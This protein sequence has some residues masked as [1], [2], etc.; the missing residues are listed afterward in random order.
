[1]L[2]TPIRPYSARD[3]GDM[4][5]YAVCFLAVVIPNSI[6]SL[7]FVALVHDDSAQMWHTG[8]YVHKSWLG[9]VQF[10]N[11]FRED[12]L[13]HLAF[14]VSP[15]LARLFI[16]IVYL[17][18]G[19]LSL[20]HLLTNY[21]Y[22]NKNV[23]LAASTLPFL[24]LG[25]WQIPLG[26]N[27]SYVAGDV[28]FSL[29]ASILICNFVKS[30][31]SLS[32]YVIKLLGFYILL[33]EVQPSSVV[34]APIIVVLAL[35][36]GRAGL[37]KRASIFFISLLS[38]FSIYTQEK[39]ASRMQPVEAEVLFDNLYAFYKG[40]ANVLS[41]GF[42]SMIWTIFFWSLTGLGLSLAFVSLLQRLRTLLFY[43]DRYFSASHI[44][45]V[46]Y[47]ASAVLLVGYVWS[48]IPY[49]LVSKNINPLFS[50][51]YY[52]IWQ[53]FGWA[54]FSVGLYQIVNLSLLPLRGVLH[55]H[56]RG[57][58]KS[59]NQVVFVSVVLL[60]S[61]AKLFH[62]HP[63]VGAKNSFMK[64]LRSTLRTEL[65]AKTYVHDQLLL[66]IKNSK[67]SRIPHYT[68]FVANT[69]Y[70]NYLVKPRRIS[71][72]TFADPAICGTHFRKRKAEVW[73]KYMVDG[74][75]TSKSMVI[76]EYDPI[77]RVLATKEYMIEIESGEVESGRGRFSF[78]ALKEGD[79]FYLDSF[80]GR[81]GLQKYISNNNIP[82]NKIAYGEAAI[83]GKCDG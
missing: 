49:A 24:S 27:I 48:L 79:I 11:A 4:F 35:T 58:S 76:L 63:A 62:Q 9:A 56:F 61:N 60:F 32:S 38:L 68:N 30:R 3:G 33:V 47:S 51:R 26:I 65:P 77:E 31:S 67:V 39:Q 45:I 7:Q 36:W 21:F 29:L 10:F 5:F 18:G 70:F 22:V 59:V 55:S 83:A 80:D 82:V 46:T 25:I 42:D 12:F 50:T 81:E 73:G 41:P 40:A 1:M 6:I 14:N 66:L 15:Q 75:N 16:V 53:F 13:F 2:N 69:G 28:L 52:F 72:V 43:R 44:E 8:H 19:S 37:L 20:F 23:A 54:A 17:G 64:S 74:F 78:Y 57:F 34:T 71:F